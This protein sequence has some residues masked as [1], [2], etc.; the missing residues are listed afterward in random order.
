MSRLPTSQEA[1]YDWHRRAML[2][3]ALLVHD[4]DP[5]CGWFVRSYDY[6]GPLYPAMIW[7]VQEIDPETGELLSDE[8]MRCTVA[9]PGDGWPSI[10]GHDSDPE[11]E[12]ASLAKRPISKNEYHILMQQVLFSNKYIGPLRPFVRW[13]DE[14]EI[15][16]DFL[17]YEGA[18][19]NAA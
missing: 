5:H 15:A 17:R 9:R 11:Y 8:R 3:E 14:R 18:M 2:G 13:F 10:A 7:M 6:R 4:S 19:N 1:L 12:W 16:A